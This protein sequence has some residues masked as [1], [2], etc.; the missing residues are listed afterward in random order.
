MLWVAS[1]PT[2]E[3]S[4]IAPLS[5]LRWFFSFF[6]W[7]LARPRGPSTLGTDSSQRAAVPGRFPFWPKLCWRATWG[8]EAGR[9]VQPGC[10]FLLPLL[11][12]LQNALRFRVFLGCWVASLP[13]IPTSASLADWRLR[14]AGRKP[15]SRWLA[16][17]FYPC[18]ADSSGTP[19][20]V[21][22][23]K[24]SIE[25]WCRVAPSDRRLC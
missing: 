21:C 7:L 20:N 9:H 24:R 13:G 16:T 2:A 14:W 11:P 15:P 23:V 25:A 22:A 5:S 3:A 10:A 1:E 19:E 6:R 17:N 4:M 12:W 8:T 18:P